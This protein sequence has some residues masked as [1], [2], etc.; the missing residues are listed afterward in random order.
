M[1]LEVGV[2][3]ASY[4]IAAR[5]QPD[6]ARRFFGL[7]FA[8]HP[9]ARA[10]FVDVEPRQREARFKHTLEVLL[11]HLHD[12]EWL[13]VTAHGLGAMY[14]AKGATRETYAWATECLL[15]VLADAAGHAWTPHVA[16]MWLTALSEVTE[17]FIEGAAEADTLVDVA[18]PTP[19]AG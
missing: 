2:V 14:L 13:D 19:L 12:G 3:R 5:R 1:A 16:Q 4:V 18:A 6:M 8:R 17:L 15:L 10:L 11:A 7:L 9:A